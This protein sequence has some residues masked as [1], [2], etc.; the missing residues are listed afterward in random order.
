MILLSRRHQRDQAT[1]I[2]INE[3]RIYELDRTWDG[4]AFNR[5]VLASRSLISVWFDPRAKFSARRNSHYF[6]EVTDLK[7]LLEHN[8]IDIDIVMQSVRSI[9]GYTIPEQ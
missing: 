2:S 7:V 1:P 9:I 4:F 8:G 5:M 6:Y 3:N